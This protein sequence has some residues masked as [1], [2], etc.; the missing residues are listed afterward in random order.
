[1]GTEEEAGITRIITENGTEHISIF[2][3]ITKQTLNTYQIE[4]VYIGGSYDATNIKVSTLSVAV[5]MLLA[6]RLRAVLVRGLIKPK[7]DGVQS[8]YDLLNGV[9]I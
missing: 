4:A 5:E 8:N 9:R 6:G 7:I 2:P 1:M 3:T